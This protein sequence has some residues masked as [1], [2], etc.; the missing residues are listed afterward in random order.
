MTA[1]MAPKKQAAPASAGRDGQR[2]T[3]QREPREPRDVPEAAAPQQAQ[4]V[5]ETA[6]PQERP[7]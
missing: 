1:M 5:P 6:A 2:G 3:G 7:A 4:A